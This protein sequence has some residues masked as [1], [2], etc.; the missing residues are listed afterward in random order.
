MEAA[1]KYYKSNTYTMCADE[2]T[3]FY[4]KSWQKIYE[5]LKMELKNNNSKSA[6]NHEK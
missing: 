5:K 1:D 4:K 3:D 2:T 6:I